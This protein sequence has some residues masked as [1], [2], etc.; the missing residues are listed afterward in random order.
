[1]Q[2]RKKVHQKSPQ[3]PEKGDNWVN[4]I[5]SNDSVYLNHT[6][7]YLERIMTM[8]SN[9]ADIAHSTPSISA[10]SYSRLM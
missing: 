2:K 3:K 1:M 6:T 7:E 10:M 8:M 4:T 5:Q 9:T